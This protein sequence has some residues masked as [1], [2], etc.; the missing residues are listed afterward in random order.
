MATTS[1][2][3][4]QI[5]LTIPAFRRLQDLVAAENAAGHPTSYTSFVSDM[6]LNYVPLEELPVG[7][8]KKTALIPT[9]GG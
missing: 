9:S 2:D 8:E 1:K 7:D 4:H 3:R 5:K 6:L